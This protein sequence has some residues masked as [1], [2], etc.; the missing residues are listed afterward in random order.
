MS[1]DSNMNNNMVRSE[2]IARV[3][4]SLVQVCKAAESDQMLQESENSQSSGLN[5]E[6]K[7][8]R[9]SASLTPSQYADA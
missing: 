1:H 4:S 9:F 6:N 3:S 7:F 8:S 5:S 2:V